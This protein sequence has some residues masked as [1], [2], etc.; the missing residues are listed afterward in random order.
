MGERQLSRT[1]QGSTAGCQVSKKTAILGYDYHTWVV[2]CVPR[3]FVLCE[4]CIVLEVSYS[5]AHWFLM[6]H[7]LAR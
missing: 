5:L 4:V 7:P 2:L 6:D 1:E 3:M